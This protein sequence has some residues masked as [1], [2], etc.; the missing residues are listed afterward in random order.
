[1][2]AI[3]KYKGSRNPEHI[4]RIAQSQGWKSSI[5]D[6]PGMIKLLKRAGIEI[7]PLFEHEPTGGLR[8]SNET[9]I[10]S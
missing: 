1:M 4:R 9:T 3:Q 2:K 7:K 8:S 10:I 5:Y 6:N